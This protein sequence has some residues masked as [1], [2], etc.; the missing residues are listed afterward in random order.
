MAREQTTTRSDPTH[1][2]WLN[3]LRPSAE[4]AIAKLWRED[5]RFAVLNTAP[6]RR[7]KK[8]R[9]VAAAG[10]ETRESRLRK[11]DDLLGQV[12][13]GLSSGALSVAAAR[14]LIARSEFTDAI[15]VAATREEAVRHLSDFFAAGDNSWDEGEVGP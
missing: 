2:S 7:N 3:A 15:R 13:A 11:L 12:C 5:H 10:V 1:A 4:R 6:R 8:G 9:I 14:E